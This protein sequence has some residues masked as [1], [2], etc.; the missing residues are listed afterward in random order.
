M[1]IVCRRF[2]RGDS[3]GSAGETVEK[4][5]KQAVKAG[6]ISAQTATAP[7]R[8]ASSRE[9]ADPG[10]DRGGEAGSHRGAIQAVS[11]GAA[12]VAQ[13]LAA[14]TAIR[15]FF[16]L[17]LMGRIVSVVA[18]STGKTGTHSEGGKYTNRRQQ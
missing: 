18:R 16:T 6:Q 12:A 10:V 1:G 17:T 7:D 4:G 5:G 14:S 2:A 11:A 3:C 15:T 13:S 8:C 9:T